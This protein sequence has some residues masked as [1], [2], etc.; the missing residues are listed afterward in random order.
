MRVFLAAQALSNTV[1]AALETL[2]ATIEDEQERTLVLTTA[3]NVR[4]VDRIFDIFNSSVLPSTKPEK[5]PTKPEKL[6]IMRDNKLINTL[7]KE[8]LPW[9]ESIKILRPERKK[10]NPTTHPKRNSLTSLRQR[11]RRKVKPTPQE[12]KETTPCILGWK[13]NVNCIKLLW[14]DLRDNLGFEYLL[15]RRLT[16]DCLE[17]FF[18]IVRNSWGHNDHPTSSIF[19]SIMHGLITNN[20]MQVAVAGANCEDDKTPLLASEESAIT[21]QFESADDPTLGNP[22]SPEEDIFDPTGLEDQTP[23]LEIEIIIDDIRYSTHNKNL[24]CIY[25]L[26]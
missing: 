11:A 17:N 5:L 18:S 13:R 9:L 7:E 19:Q 1:A 22:Q 24:Q 15:T 4:K 10:K 26:M 8:F 16:Q 14:E 21:K 2:A 3:K 12:K 23:G 6:P 25:I 20:V